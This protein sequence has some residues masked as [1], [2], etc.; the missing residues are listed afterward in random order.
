MCVLHIHCIRAYSIHCARP[1]FHKIPL[2]APRKTYYTVVYLARRAYFSCASRCEKIT[3][4]VAVRCSS[5][6]NIRFRRPP[7]PLPLSIYNVHA[8][9]AYRAYTAA[10]SRLFIRHAK[11]IVSYYTFCRSRNACIYIYIYIFFIRTYARIKPLFAHPISHTGTPRALWEPRVGRRQ[12]SS[13]L[14]TR[15]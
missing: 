8:D 3:P 13:V 12:C 1:R 10:R 6:H 5:V 4:L 2:T 15:P 9:L 7:L 11:T 14:L